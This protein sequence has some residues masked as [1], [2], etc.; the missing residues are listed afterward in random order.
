MSGTAGA[1]G[2]SLHPVGDLHH[3]VGRLDRLGRQLVGALGLD[4]VD[5]RVRAMSVLEASSAPCLMS[6][7][8]ARRPRCPTR[9]WSRRRCRRRTQ[10]LRRA[11]VDERR[12]CRR[13]A[14]GRD[15][16]VAGRSRSGSAWTPFGIVIVRLDEAAGAGRRAGR[17]PSMCRSPSRV[18]AWR[19]SDSL[20]LR[21]PSPSMRTSSGSPV[22]L[23]VAL[24][25]AAAVVRRCA[26]PC[27]AARRRTSSARP[28]AL[29]QRGPR[30]RRAGA[31]THSCSRW[32]GRSRRHPA[33]AAAR[34]CLR[35]RFGV[36][37]ALVPRSAE[38]R[39][40]L[41]RRGSRRRTRPCRASRRSCG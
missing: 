32:R 20:T 21:K 6:S 22:L 35:R 17:W 13:S 18:S 23:E 4:H 25:E 3:L 8:R 16:A 31:C 29:V 5:H 15:G 7:R 11:D 12:A 36:L 41:G 28:A 1:G 2:S 27:R 40:A 19:P 26:R 10:A 39:R 34:A 24:L 9:R 33:S 38:G 30:T 37:R 14:G